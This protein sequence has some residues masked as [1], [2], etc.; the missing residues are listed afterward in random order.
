MRNDDGTLVQVIIITLSS[1]DF[2]VYYFVDFKSK[3]ID[4]KNDFEQSS[5]Y[6][7]DC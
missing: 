3:S 2:S 1:T 5:I 7:S 4:S 6:L